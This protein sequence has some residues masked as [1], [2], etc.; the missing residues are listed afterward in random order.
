MTI[1]EKLELDALRLRVKELEQQALRH[2]EERER[3]SIEAMIC[4]LRL[5]RN[6][7]EPQQYRSLVVGMAYYISWHARQAAKTYNAPDLN[8][9]MF[10]LQDGLVTDI[11]QTPESGTGPC[12]KN[13]EQP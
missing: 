7:R 5:A 11:Q 9:S 12:R 6:H 10:D 1:D 3:A 2:S 13:Q 4:M 8:I